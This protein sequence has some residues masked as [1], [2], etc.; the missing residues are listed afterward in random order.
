MMPRSEIGAKWPKLSA[1]DLA[2]LK[3][4]DDLISQVVSKFGIE[5]A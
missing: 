3:G 4:K 1:N 5:K 2:T